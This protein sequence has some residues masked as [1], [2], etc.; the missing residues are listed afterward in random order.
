MQTKVR[1]QGKCETNNQETELQKA[2]RDPKGK[3]LGTKTDE[4][5]EK[6]KDKGG[7]QWVKGTDVTVIRI[8][9]MDHILP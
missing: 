8:I 2:T 3:T 5:G 7:K 1:K 9:L 6:Y 4:H